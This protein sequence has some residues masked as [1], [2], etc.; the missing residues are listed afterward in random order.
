MRGAKRM[1]PRAAYSAEMLRTAGLIAIVALVLVGAAWAGPAFNLDDHPYLG[2]LIATFAGVFAGGALALGVDRLQET[3]RRRVEREHDETLRDRARLAELTLQR[4]V[5]GLLHDELSVNAEAMADTAGRARRP[6]PD[7]FY[8]PLLSATWQ[9]LSASGEISHVPTPDLL[10]AFAEAYHWVGIV[11]RFEQQ[12]LDLQFHPAGVTGALI[13]EGI[14]G[15]ALRDALQRLKAQLEPLDEPAGSVIGA[16][17]RLANEAFE[18]IDDEI[19]AVE[20][21]VAATLVSR[22]R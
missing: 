8:T 19:A 10:G 12:M 18:M 7:L 17:V 11:N 13:G 15:K 6:R 21:K 1:T 5:V 2:L 16:A 3:R 20:G 4:R 14:G 9:A 22:Q